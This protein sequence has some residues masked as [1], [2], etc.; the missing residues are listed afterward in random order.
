MCIYISK[1]PTKYVEKI[2]H[3]LLYRNEYLELPRS[4]FICY[5][6]YHFLQ[7]IK[8]DLCNGKYFKSYIEVLKKKKC[9]IFEHFFTFS[10]I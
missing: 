6:I 7:H 5:W 1:I 2:E 3:F 10:I 4:F 8:K 9:Y